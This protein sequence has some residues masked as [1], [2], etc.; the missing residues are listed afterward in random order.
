MVI[1]GSVSGRD[2]QQI[3]NLLIAKQ[4]RCILDDDYFRVEVHLSMRAG[5]LRFYVF[6]CVVVLW[7]GSGFVG[8]LVCCFDFGL[9]H[10]CQSSQQLTWA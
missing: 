2:A 6:C 3:Y 4:C 9:F 1:E 8:C 5:R 10:P 7:F